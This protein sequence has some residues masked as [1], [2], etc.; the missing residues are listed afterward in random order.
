MKLWCCACKK[1]VEPHLEWGSDIYPHRPDLAGRPFWQCHECMNFVGCHWK[2]KS[3]TRP[4]GCIPTPE[5]KNA[6]RHIHE[7]IDPLWQS[8]RIGRKRLYGE[9]TELI[10]RQYHTADLRTIDEARLVYRKA[11]EIARRLDATR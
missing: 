4:L 3:P 1:E 9:L 5:L 11:K 2:T 6:R 8:G 10:G 7:L